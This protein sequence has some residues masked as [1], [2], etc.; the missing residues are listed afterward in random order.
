MTTTTSL[1][2]L[3]LALCILAHAVAGRIPAGIGTTIFASVVYAFALI[4]VVALLL[5]VLL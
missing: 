1:E 5:R 2:V 3:V 4:L